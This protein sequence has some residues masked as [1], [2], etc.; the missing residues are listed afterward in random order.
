[1]FCLSKGRT[2]IY[3]ICKS[4]KQRQKQYAII[5]S[6][7]FPG[8]TYLTIDKCTHQINAIYRRYITHISKF[9]LGQL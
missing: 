4:E 2:Y 8:R 1:M 3:N 5:F 7:D 9:S 6:F